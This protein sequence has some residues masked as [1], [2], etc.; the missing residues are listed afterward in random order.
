M[1]KPDGNDQFSAKFIKDLRR[2]G[3]EVEMGEYYTHKEFFFLADL[4]NFLKKNKVPDKLIV[5]ISDMV[6][7]FFI[8]RHVEEWQNNKKQSKK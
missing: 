6:G 7:D 2:R 3:K 1:R 5:K 4:D 8:A